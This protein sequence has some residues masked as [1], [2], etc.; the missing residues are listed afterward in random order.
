M[1]NDA[2]VFKVSSASAG[3]VTPEEWAREIEQVARE[4]NIFRG[5]TGS[6]IVKDGVGV[7][8]NTL[9]IQKNT[10]LSAAAVTDGDSVPV[11]A[12]SFSQID[13]TAGIIGVST[14]IT[15]KQLRDQLA[16]VKEDVIMNMGLA[17]AE[18]EENDIITELMTTSSAAIYANGT[19]STTITSGD[20]FN[21]ALFNE[22]IVA[23]RSD[24]RKAMNL[25]IHP[26]QEGALRNLSQFTDAS[27]LGDDRVNR[28]GFI[29]RFFGV[30][31]YVSTNTNT[32]LEGSASDVTVYKALM[33]GPR[34]AVLFDKKRPT[35]KIDD[36]IVNDLSTT[37]LV[38]QDFG[39]QVLN[40]E[41]IR[42]LVSA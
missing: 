25:V 34:A 32:A 26:V 30:D 3:Y 21:V 36:G 17:I 39:V 1:A 24:K 14:Q 35:L 6:I 10:A 9:H 5:L 42:I 19:D 13:V 16:S 27:Q 7:E 22:G 28:E 41:S 11:S 12:L 40:D 4:A 31:V 33:L 18:K 2:N 20:T 37:F 8:G 38:Y 15:W 29:G 23:M